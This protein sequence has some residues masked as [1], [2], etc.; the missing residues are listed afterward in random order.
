VLGRV[1]TADGTTYV[2]LPGKWRLRLCQDHLPPHG[3]QVRVAFR[4]EHITVDPDRDDAGLNELQASVKGISYLG[5]RYEYLLSAADTEFTVEAPRRL[6]AS[7]GES[8]LVR[9]DP[10]AVKIWPE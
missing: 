8:L 7:E 5:D 2:E 3:T 1:I 9:I 6:R 4:P 10:E